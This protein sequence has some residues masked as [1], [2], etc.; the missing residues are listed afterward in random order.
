V[1]FVGPRDLSAYIGKLNKM[2]D[3]EL[4]ALIARV[5][6]AALKA[7]KALGTV[8]PTG[9]VARQ[10]FERGYGLLISG[11]DMTH[12]RASILQMMKDAGRG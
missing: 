5:E 9:A 10:L 7:G 1:V 8:A 4:R 6:E 2:D 12:L 3:P 11:N